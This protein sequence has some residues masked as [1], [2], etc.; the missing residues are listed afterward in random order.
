[1]DDKHLLYMEVRRLFEK[2]KKEKDI[3]SFLSKKGHSK[4]EINELIL[5]Y[6][7]DE[8]TKR[9]DE[10]I[11][12]IEKRFSKGESLETVAF[13]LSGKYGAFEV[14]KALLR[15]ELTKFDYRAFFF[16]LIKGGKVFFA[17]LID[18]ILGIFV[19]WVF[20]ILV[21]LLFITAVLHYAYGTRRGRKLSSEEVSAEAD[22]LNV[23]MSYPGGLF[24]TQGRWGYSPKFGVYPRFWLMNLGVSF[25]LMHLMFGAIL[26]KIS[27]LWGILSFASGILSVTLL[28]FDYR[29]IV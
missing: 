7:K 24:I 1:M 8:S 19:N 5:E 16:D 27:A 28:Y 29:K 20:F 6:K 17:I 22:K 12:E 2:K 4:E 25:F 21:P 11:K 26:L 9:D 3:V 13:E 18:V 23:E 15:A 14:K 10:L